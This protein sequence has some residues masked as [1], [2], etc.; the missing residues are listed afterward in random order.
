MASDWRMSAYFYEG[1]SGRNF[2]H[3]YDCGHGR[4]VI[5]DYFKGKTLIVHG[6]KFEE[7]V[8]LEG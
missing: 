4:D 7:R 8:E 2:Y 3:D 1:T 5:K 6:D